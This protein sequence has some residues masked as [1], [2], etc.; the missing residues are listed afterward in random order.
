MDPAHG[1][2]HEKSSALKI[3]DRTSQNYEETIKLTMERLLECEEHYPM[4]KYQLK[5]KEKSCEK[6]KDGN[7]YYLTQSKM[8]L[9]LELF[10]QGIAYAPLSSK[11][12]AKGYANRSA[13]TYVTGHHQDSLK[14]IERALKIGYPDDL[15]AKLYARRAKNL[16]ALDP[17]MRP[18][19][20][21]AISQA[22][23]WMSAMNFASRKKIENI[24]QE[25]VDIFP[26]GIEDL[27]PQKLVFPVPST[28]TKILRAS[29]AIAIKYNEQSGRH[30]VATRNIDVGETVLV[31]EPYA[32]II[33]P[34]NLYRYCWHCYKLV[35]SGIPC[36]ECV[37]VIYCDENCLNEAW[38]EHHHIECPII[39][40][41][42]LNNMKAPEIMGLR[43]LVKALNEMG[44]I[45]NLKDQVDK[46]NLLTDP[47]NKLLTD[48]IFD[49]TKYASVFGLAADTSFLWKLPNYT[50]QLKSIFILY[51]LAATTDNI[52][53][54]KITDFK[55]LADDEQA[56]FIGG[57]LLKHFDIVLLNSCSAQIFRDEDEDEFI[58]GIM[59]L[60]LISL[61]NHS[62][63][64]NMC[65]HTS[66]PS[67]A[68]NAVQ[69]IKQGE[70][71]TLNYGA[72]FQLHSTEDRRKVL[73]NRYNFLCNCVAC[74]N[75]WDPE[76]EFPSLSELSVPEEIM[77]RFRMA[78]V[79]DLENYLSIF[80]F[81]SKLIVD[82]SKTL[83]SILKLFKLFEEIN[84]SSPCAEMINHR[85]ALVLLYF[86]GSY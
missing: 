75:N 55:D 56:L 86:Q 48:G 2:W 70:Q 18:E 51:Y 19:V 84:I 22:R 69:T 21:E 20:E 31:H 72:D 41:M 67:V 32:T 35:M 63:F 29:D 49:D 8:E 50:Y 71:L 23:H 10:T 79:E 5:S 82:V 68:F 14:D 25:L 40:S 6:I 64:F 11:E 80:N 45:E 78:M 30:I 4:M 9:A 74:L 12:L 33:T 16:L 38:K 43:M 81:E 46:L 53:D 44:S 47:V 52:F 37:N 60:P 1:Y 65:F 15:K 73:K 36:H 54:G 39:T 83:E 17:T 28:N 57:L 62:C 27:N 76:T 85:S 59:L 26:T 3:P 77:R 24:L 42:L 58:R 13:V 61:C 66:G 34:E 7:K